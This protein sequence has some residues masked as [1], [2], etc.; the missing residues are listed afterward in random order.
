METIP[1]TV[2][3]SNDEM[4]PAAALHFDRNMGKR[5]RLTQV[6]AGLMIAFG[7]FSLR[8]EILPLSGF[9][10]AAGI[11]GLLIRHFYIKRCIQAGEKSPFHGETQTWSIRNND[12]LIE[13]PGQESKLPFDQLT[14]LRHSPDGLLLYTGPSSFFWLPSSGFKSKESF[15]EALERLEK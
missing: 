2:T 15:H 7:I 12:I 13:R 9:L 5:W 3:F 8:Y 4:R 11:L 14:K 10:I 1:V 6:F